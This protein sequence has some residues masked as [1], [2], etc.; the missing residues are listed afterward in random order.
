MNYDSWF[1]R[2]T[3]FAPHPWQRELGADVDCRDRL[4]RIPTG[5][6]KTA[7]TVLPWVHR[8]VVAGDARWP[9]RLVFCLPM[10]VLVE[11]TE[12]A[13]QA[14]IRQA[15]LDV[16]VVVLLGGRHESSWLERPELPTIVVGTQDMLLS[17]ALGRG[18]GSARGLWPMEM[19]MLHRDALWVIDEV[20]LMDVGL[21]TTTQLH[22]FRR[23]DERAGRPSFRPTYC[24]WMSATLQ[25]SW[26]DSVDHAPHRAQVA[27][28]Q[29]GAALRERGL[30]AVQ[31]ALTTRADLATPEEVA[32]LAIAA[33][34]PATTTLV[35]VNTVD[36]ARKVHDALAKKKRSAELV[37]SRFRAGDRRAWTFLRR[38]AEV[39]PEGRIIVATQVVEAG[40]DISAASLIT[41]LAPWSSLV[42][43]F[44]RCAR[45]EGQSGKVV[46]VGAPPADEKK[47]APYSVEALC[48]ASEALS[49]VGADV[50]PA[51]LEAFE[52]TLAR[53]DGPFLARL[54]PYV[55]LHVLR[56]RDF[57]D[58]F[59]TTPDLSGADLDVS[60]Y[61]RTGEDRDVS[62][63]WRDVPPGHPREIDAVEA[64]AREELCPVPLSELIDFLK[65]KNHVYTKD[66]LTGRWRRVDRPVPG[67]T[68]LVD[69]AAGGYDPRRGWDLKSTA[70]VAPLPRALDPRPFESAAESAD[71]EELSAYPWKTIRTHGREAGSEASKLGRAL[72]LDPALVDLLGLVGRWHDA[73]KAHP[74][75]Q[76]AIADAARELGGSTAG[77]RDLAKA[78]A[79]AWRRPPYPQRPG[80]RHE[81]VSTL[82]MFELL[83]RA[84]P[85]HPGLAAVHAPLLSAI[86]A[87]P[88]TPTPDEHASETALSA[89]LAALSVDDLDL[90]LYLV[91][92]HHGKVR[93]SWS[94]TPNDQTEGH[95]GIHGVCDGDVVGGFELSDR[96]GRPATVP[97]LRV[98]LAPAALGLNARYGASWSDRVFGLLERLG[99]F[100]LAYLEGLFRVA[101]WRAS[102]LDTPEDA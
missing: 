18:Y 27:V 89:E 43:R 87:P 66:Y 33:H 23:A 85:D 84:R 3:G 13:I 1:E 12:A 64:P 4:L 78:P 59:D 63:F 16:A 71:D 53:D 44:G 69:A 42:Q 19:G 48:S 9:N 8:R 57:D 15:G 95:G 11:Q 25:P 68:L 72:G 7:G 41:D 94:T 6:G 40:V 17:R 83:F 51:S 73:G 56:R 20:Q 102:Q 21:A 30:W 22:A 77:R 28:T 47:A 74:V 65:L 67:M 81:L 80:F 14:W 54:Y 96:M 86:G 2:L 58:L 88:M 99:P 97:D 32:G 36:R 52:D 100:S 31:K 98:S 49:R 61:I 26:M 82:L 55:P 35:M 76:A 10:R 70:R 91:C 93:T 37:H 46:V 38:D 50:G 24:W 29:I 39:L 101:D 92:A 34:E 5:F 45:Y 62:V 90:A 79:D 60:R 75:F